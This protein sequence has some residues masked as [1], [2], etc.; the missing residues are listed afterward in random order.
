[1]GRPGRSATPY[2]TA[3]LGYTEVLSQKLQ[4]STKNIHEAYGNVQDV[5]AAIKAA[6]SEVKFD[7]LWEEICKLNGGEAISKPRIVARQMM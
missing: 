1:M 5:I 2:N 3:M 6:R 7:V 4:G